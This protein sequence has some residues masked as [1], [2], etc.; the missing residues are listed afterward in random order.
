MKRKRR[1]LIVVLCVIVGVVLIASVVLRLVLTRER[2]IALIVPRVEKAVQAEIRIGDI[3]ISF[4]FGFGVDV[5]D[6]AFRKALPDGGG[7]S[8]VSEKVVF[9]AS[10]LSLIRRRPEIKKI[11]V[12][13]G[14]LTMAG[15]PRRPDVLLGGV[16][17]GMSVQPV[18]SGYSINA[19][20]A[21]DSVSFARG[22]RRIE[23]A[24]ERI[25]FDGTLE[26]DRDFSRITLDE[27]TVRWNDLVTARLTGEV[28]NLKT[29]QDISLQVE[30]PDNRLAP[31][32]DKIL[33]FPLHEIIPALKGKQ[34]DRL[35]PVNVKEGRFGFDSKIDGSMKDPSSLQVS[36]AL[37]LNDLVITHAALEKPVS[38]NGSFTFSDRGARSEELSILF[39]ASKGDLTVGIT[40][41]DGKS[42]QHVQFGGDLD[43]AIE[44]LTSLSKTTEVTATGKVRATVKGG[45]PPAVLANL[46]PSQVKSVTPEQIARAWQHVTLDGDV[47][48]EGV[49]F[50]AEGSPFRVF[51][52]K[53][54]ANIAGGNVERVMAEFSLNGSPFTCK[55]TL[56]GI[57][58]AMAEMAS[59]VPKQAK[60]KTAS[61]YLDPGGILDG[62]KN[63]PVY[64]VELT[65]RSLD[66]RPFEKAT[67]GI[68]DRQ[69]GAGTGK[70]GETGTV[71]SPQ[72]LAGNPIMLLSLKNTSFTA[73]LDS[74]VA[75]KA[76]FT[77]VH[78]K[79]TIRD[80]RLKADP[81]TLDYAGGKGRAVLNSDLRTPG[82]VRSK[83][84]VSFD[85]VE[86]GKA[87]GKLH[88]L[89]NL[90]QG[91]FT[92]E[93]RADFESGPGI[94]PLMTISATGAASSSMGN[95]SLSP[96]IASLR[97]AVP[98]DLS[99]IERFD[100]SEW[101]GNFM[102]RDGRFI[103]EGWKITSPKGYW[104]IKGSFGFDG[105]LD[106]AVNLVIPPTVQRE[107]K[108]LGKY[109]DVVDLIR[110]REGNLVL[111]LHLG[112][113]AKSPKVSLDLSKAKAKATDKVI[114]S[115]RKK[116][117]DYL[118][119]K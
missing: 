25:R 44:D 51:G 24:L 78:A 42:V 8:F 96:F 104:T 2:L 61:P 106:Y 5:H 46:F 3:G 50:S 114:D 4:P 37:K 119:K 90:V 35:L 110:D 27:S 108:D 17:A 68:G 100:F 77:R 103:T 72:P 116:L 23:A 9:R 47:E 93:S 40:L 53:G 118:K 67:P 95:I 22:G 36:G 74:V 71:V 13:G 97:E 101:Q 48:I 112:G 32:V 33:S 19:S 49:N 52:L 30:S 58:P 18:E 56:T 105:T 117:L 80:G 115:V 111:D 34:P 94:N 79:G 92:F 14:T 10:L 91:V 76:I 6:L 7:L 75:S 89:G 65:G 29:K 28:R 102:V 87:L 39:G 15:T 81:V 98:F 73:Q 11:E 21:I 82:R 54:R 88:S 41:S 64:T 63:V 57:M 113:M 43:L 1:N 20:V 69:E 70:P 12:R 99:P 86:A 84:N 26:S 16:E 83:V 109:P 38:M 45:A 66:V 60:D 62:M 31:V 55:A 107:M 85:G 59:L